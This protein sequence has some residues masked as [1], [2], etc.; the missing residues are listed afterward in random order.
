MQGNHVH[1]F[2]DGYNQSSGKYDLPT[3]IRLLAD[4]YARFYKLPEIGTDK[5]LSADK[6]KRVGEYIQ[7]LFYQH[8]NKHLKA[9]ILNWHFYPIQTNARKSGLRS[10]NR[11][12]YQSTNAS[13]VFTTAPKSKPN[14]LKKTLNRRLKR[15]KKAKVIAEQ[16]EQKTRQEKQQL[17]LLM[18]Q[19]Q[20][21]AEKR[22]Q[23]EL[24]TH[25]LTYQAEQARKEEQEA[26]AF[27]DFVFRLSEALNK[28]WTSLMKKV[29]EIVVIKAATDVKNSIDAFS[30]PTN[31]D[32][33][34][35]LNQ[36]I[37]LEYERATIVEK[38]QKLSEN[39]KI[40]NYL[41][42]KRRR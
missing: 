41:H 3:Q 32:F 36:F 33:V 24:E 1:I 25:V 21:A 5:Q 35:Q 40:S 42:I 27:L 16:A 14:N 22:K 12:I 31:P 23:I 30:T 7:Q 9:R 11:P 34:N 15:Q 13:L 8:A 39:A 20:A 28:W 6:N 18:Q 10:E 17:E 2:V 19:Q 4:K 38:A 37:R 29:P 26:R